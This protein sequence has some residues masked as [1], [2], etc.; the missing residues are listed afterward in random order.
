MNPEPSDPEALLEGYRRAEARRRPWEALWRDCATHALP[1]GTAVAA[2]TYDA[3]AADAAEQLAASLLAE[4]TPP[5]ERWVGFEPGGE[6]GPDA[7]D[8]LEEA[9]AAVQGH[10]D[11]SAFAV[12]MHQALL[13]LVVFGTGCLLFEE[14]ALGRPSAFR[15]TAVPLAE[16]VLEEG[17]EGRLDRVWRRRE[18]GPA[19]LRDR[20]PRA[21]V[22][23]GEGPFGV[24][25]RVAP[26]A[27]G[28]ADASS[29]SGGAD[30]ASSMNRR[31]PRGGYR[32]MAVLEGGGGR[33]AQ[34]LAEGRFAVSP[35]FSAGKGAG[36]IGWRCR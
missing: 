35:S 34:M 2:R 17:T 13:D 11:R 10:L 27:G 9:A 7:V 5:F 23:N 22:L 26:E 14:S 18:L 36:V 12:E 15:F 31:V 25:E 30:A 28:G 4:L 21:P 33:A 8:A 16:T 1:G 20:F 6:A 24:V 32:Y 29:T 19:D 3:T